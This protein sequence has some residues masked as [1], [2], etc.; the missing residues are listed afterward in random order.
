MDPMVRAFRANDGQGGDLRVKRNI[1]N[2]RYGVGGNRDVV[3]STT[4]RPRFLTRI[5]LETIYRNFAI[6]AKVVDLKPDDVF[7]PGII[8]SGENESAV[9]TMQDEFDRLG[10]MRRI[11]DAAKAARLF[12]TA[13]VIFAPTDGRFEVELK[14]EE[15]QQGDISHILIADKFNL[16]EAKVYGDP[17]FPK[18]G[19]PFMY[20]WHYRPAS[21]TMSVMM[22]E[23]RGHALPTIDIHASRVLRFDGI[24]P[25]TSDGWEG[26]RDD[27]WGLSIMNRLL[28][29]ILQDEV[30]AAALQDLV[31]RSYIPIFQIARLR[32]ALGLGKE[33]PKEASIDDYINTMAET[34]PT[35]NAIFLDKDDEVSEL[36]VHAAGIAEIVESHMKRIATLEGIP[37]TR[38]TG[39]SATGLSA[40]GE[41]DARD[42]RITIEAYR[43]R[44]IEPEW[45]RMMEVV[46]RNAGLD[47]PPEWEWGELG[48][49]TAEETANIAFLQA[50]TVEKLIAAGTINE[51]EAREFLNK[52]E[53][54][55]LSKMF[56]PPEIAAIGIE[57]AKA[58]VEMTKNPPKPPAPAGG[59]A[60]GANGSKR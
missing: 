37:I 46:A 50:Q 24:S 13:V 2:D 58:D 26:S 42:Y 56:E 1:E 29:A 51:D 22:S 16:E 17:R 36:K 44:A 54:L 57:Q 28:D 12:G 21:G 48:E 8:W 38:F 60:N 47:E 43:K 25:L 4:L 55:D 23:L 20:R 14:P 18:F 33:N 39:E 40:T 11:P 45:D 30:Q 41:G 31:K 59:G 34:L 10:I 15:V 9:E 49:A 27:R 19:E 6:A 52:N 5:Y 32:D 3:G 35:S 7:S 53:W